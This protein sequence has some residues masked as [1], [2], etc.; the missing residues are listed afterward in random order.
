MSEYEI[1]EYLAYHGYS[2]KEDLPCFVYANKAIARQ[3]KQQFDELVI[4]ELISLLT[5][6]LHLSYE[7]VAGIVDYNFVVSVLGTEFFEL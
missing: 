4:E 6:A 5:E 3:Y 1:V 7:Q 2:L